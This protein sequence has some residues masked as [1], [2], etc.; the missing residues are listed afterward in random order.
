M[1]VASSAPQVNAI[2]NENKKPSVSP[3]LRSVGVAG[4]SVFQTKKTTNVN[5]HTNPPLLLKLFIIK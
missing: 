4:T 3:P 1:R 5:N 2:A